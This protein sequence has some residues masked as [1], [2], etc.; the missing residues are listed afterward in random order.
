MKTI[1]KEETITKQITEYEA[2]DGTVFTTEE[3]CRKW[4]QSAKC[5][6]NANA[7]PLLL[8]RSYVNVYE[9]QPFGGEDTAYHIHP[10]DEKEL[11]A[12]TQWMAQFDCGNLPTT[13]IIGKDVLVIVDGCEYLYWATPDKIKEEFCKSV[14]ALLF[15]AEEE[16]K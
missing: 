6:I 13:D 7:K 11:K 5:A 15:K 1:R 16:E 4:E 8:E 3:E 14:D 2:F 10:N 12:I 9:M